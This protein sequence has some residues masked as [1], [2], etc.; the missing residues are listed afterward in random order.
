MA[1]V[2]ALPGC[3]S[4]GKTMDEAVANITEAIRGVL[5][6]MERNGNPFRPDS[7]PAFVGE[8]AV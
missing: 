5:K 1:D 2:P 6:A 3:M 8:I 4:Q 7:Y